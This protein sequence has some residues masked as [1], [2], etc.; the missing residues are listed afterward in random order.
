MKSAVDTAKSNVLSEL[1]DYMEAVIKGITN[2]KS[3]N[4]MNAEITEATV[5]G[6]ALYNTYKNTQDPEKMKDLID[7]FDPEIMENIDG[8]QNS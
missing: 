2:N 6:A 1:K 5:K 8:T 7:A 4:G 3:T